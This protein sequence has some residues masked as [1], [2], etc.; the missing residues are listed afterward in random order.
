MLIHCRCGNI[1]AV[2]GRQPGVLTIICPACHM[3]QT[4][5]YTPVTQLPVLPDPDPEPEETWMSDYET[6]TAPV[7][8]LSDKGWAEGRHICNAEQQ[9]SAGL[10]CTAMY[11]QGIMHN[12]HG[13]PHK[14]LARRIW[15]RRQG[16]CHYGTHC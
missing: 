5:A 9:S 12:H 13:R 14:L 2:Y 4:V 16:A 10:P 1:L 6:C 7:T 3:P 11:V 8:G 15:P